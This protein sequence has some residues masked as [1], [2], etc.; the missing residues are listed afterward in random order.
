M[1]DASELDAVDAL[2][3]A[4][5]D[6]ELDQAGREE[7]EGLIA[8]DPAVAAR[9]RAFHQVDSVVRGIGRNELEPE[10]LAAGYASIEERLGIGAGARPPLWRRPAFGLALAAAAVLL[11]YLSGATESA[12]PGLAEGDAPPNVAVLDEIADDLPNSLP[13]GDAPL[14]EESLDAFAVALGY[15]EGP[16][17]TSPVPGLPMEDFEIIDQ[18][19]LLE[20]LAAREAEGRG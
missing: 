14:E 20:Y 12:R 8:A 9:V 7:L 17:G 2:I 19:E 11:L 18:L 3:S 13:H 10:R 15:A 1:K 6:D 16:D 5:M 4:A